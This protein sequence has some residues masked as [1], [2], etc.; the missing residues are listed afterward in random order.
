M[1]MMMLVIKLGMMQQNIL[2]EIFINMSLF[3]LHYNLFD[4]H[5]HHHHRVFSLQQNRYS[6]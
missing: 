4:N 3:I 2:L 6:K 5:H 1:I